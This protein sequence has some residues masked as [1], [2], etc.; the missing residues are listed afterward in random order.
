MRNAAAR[1]ANAWPKP[2]AAPV[3]TATLAGNSNFWG[4]LFAW[5]LMRGF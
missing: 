5:G 3:M 4:L 1:C 2:L